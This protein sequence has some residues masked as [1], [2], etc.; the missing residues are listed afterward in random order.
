MSG[1]VL[2][3]LLA[4][5]AV[6]LWW[7]LRRWRSQTSSVTALPPP[8]RIDTEGPVENDNLDDRMIELDRLLGEGQITRE[9]YDSRRRRLYDGTNG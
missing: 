7:L 6:L 5:F 4:A 2:F 3:L 9:E 8:G 1:P